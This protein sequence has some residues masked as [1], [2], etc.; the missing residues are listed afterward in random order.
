MDEFAAQIEELEHQW[1]RRWMARDRKGMK[2]LATN[3]FVF[4]LG[5]QTSA[6]LDRP[7]WLE[8]TTSRFLCTGYRFRDIYVRRHKKLAVFAARMSIEARLGPK[9]IEGD[10]WITDLWQQGGIRR[11]WRLVERT[12]SRP[13]TTPELPEIIHEMQLW[14]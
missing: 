5:G 12:M 14:R 9:K 7:S 1:M 3:E 4:L 10:V 11:K 13:D 2:A 8:A 6:M